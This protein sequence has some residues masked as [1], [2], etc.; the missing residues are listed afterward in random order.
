MKEYNTNQASFMLVNIANEM[1]KKHNQ[2]Q[3]L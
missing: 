3:L 2:K 1:Q